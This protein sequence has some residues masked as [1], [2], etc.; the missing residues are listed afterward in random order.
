MLEEAATLYRRARRGFHEREDEQEYLLASQELAGVLRSMNKDDEAESMYRQV[1]ERLEELHGADSSQTNVVVHNLG[2]LL[3]FQ[4]K[5]RLD[6]AEKLFRRAEKKY[7]EVHGEHHQRTSL[8]IAALGDVMQARN[9]LSEAEALY[10]RAL[11]AQEAV[12]GPT[13]PC[14]LLSGLY[15]LAVTLAKLERYAE[16]APLFERLAVGFAAH[17]NDHRCRAKL[18]SARWN[19]TESARLA[20]EKAVQS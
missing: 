19:A 20:L 13:H 1:L 17:P 18:K 16:A 6:E 14:T 12:L 10:R 5:P 9:R 2:H 3:L 15:N 8:A 4:K 11:A 7:Q